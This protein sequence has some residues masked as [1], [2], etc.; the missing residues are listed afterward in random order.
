MQVHIRQA[1][2]IDNKSDLN[3][4]VADIIIEK[5]SLIPTV[6]KG[7]VA[8]SSISV[9]GKEVWKGKDLCISPGWVDVFA[10]YREPG[11]EQKENIHSGVTLIH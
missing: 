1:K 7:R 10:D 6:V 4:K 11:F 8:N 2:I 9:D 5:G 3:D